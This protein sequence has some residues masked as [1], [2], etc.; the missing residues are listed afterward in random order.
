MLGNKILLDV[1]LLLS[2][3]TWLPRLLDHASFVTVLF[4]GS[5]KRL[6][7]SVWKTKEIT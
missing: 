5:E 6:A 1:E 2:E 3:R 4:S 7:F